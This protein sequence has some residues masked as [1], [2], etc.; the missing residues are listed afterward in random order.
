M[1]DY[2]IINNN[3]SLGKLGISKQV[4]HAIAKHA[5]DEVMPQTNV[6]MRIIHW[7]LLKPLYTHFHRDGSVSIHV[8]LQMERHDGMFQTNEMVQKL[9]LEKINEH[10][11]LTNVKIHIHLLKIK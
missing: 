4:F 8:Y 10:V 2:L 9:I 6:R 5:I 3:N 7:D 1:A 11:G